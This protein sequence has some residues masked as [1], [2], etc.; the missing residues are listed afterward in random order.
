VEQNDGLFG[1]IGRDEA[2]ISS[3]LGPPLT[4]RAVGDDLWLVFS[5][6]ALQLRVRCRPGTDGPPRVASWTAT[7]EAGCPTLAEAAAAVGLWPAVAPDVAAV[8]VTAPLLRRPLPRPDGRV[9]SFTAT[10]RYGQ[11]TQVS[12]FDETPDWTESPARG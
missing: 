4:R 9:H 12:V 5:S 11:I 10:V 1:L 2:E 6:P 3:R 7:F 8:D